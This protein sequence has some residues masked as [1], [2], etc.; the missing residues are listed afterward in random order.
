MLAKNPLNRLN[1]NLDQ[2]GLIPDGQCG[3][4]KDRG[5]IDMLFTARQLQVECQEQTVDRRIT[6]VDLK[7]SVLRGF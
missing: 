5:T 3:F 7:Q 2:T 1:L 6:F 4:R